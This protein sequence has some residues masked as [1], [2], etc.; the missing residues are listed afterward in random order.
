M[1][2]LGRFHLPGGLSLLTPNGFFAALRNRDWPRVE[3]WAVSHRRNPPRKA[4]R[5]SPARQPGGSFFNLWTLPPP[6]TTS[7]GSRAVIRRCT[8][9]AT[10]RRHFLL[11]CLFSPRM[12]TY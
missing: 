8:T 5:L 3:L 7:S 12:P 6:S 10:S 1:L 2:Y 9:S 11:P 4:L